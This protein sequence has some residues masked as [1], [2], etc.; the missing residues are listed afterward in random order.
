MGS[1][2]ISLD[3][4]VNGEQYRSVKAKGLSGHGQ[5]FQKDPNSISTSRAM[6]VTFIGRRTPLGVYVTRYITRSTYVSQVPFLS[7]H[8]SSGRCG[9]ND[10]FTEA[11]APTSALKIFVFVTSCKWQ[12]RVKSP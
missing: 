12:D 9:R 10:I 2:Y 3:I 11:S 1:A 6:C 4:H 8:I 7:F 5:L